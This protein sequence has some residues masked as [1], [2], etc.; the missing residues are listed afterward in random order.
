MSHIEAIRH[1]EMDHGIPSTLSIFLTLGN[2]VATPPK[3]WRWCD[4][5]HH[6]KLYCEDSVSGRNF[7]VHLVAT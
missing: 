6:R 5:R 2:V 7:G 3:P 4:Y 1:G